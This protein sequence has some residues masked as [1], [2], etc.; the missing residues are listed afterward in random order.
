MPEVVVF[1]I[2]FGFP[3]L[4]RCDGQIAHVLLTRSPLVY[5]RRGLTARLA[6]VKH[7][8]SVR[9]EPGS[10][11]PLKSCG[12][13]PRREP[14]FGVSR[15]ELASH[16]DAGL[17]KGTVDRK[18]DESLASADGA[19]LSFVDFW[20]AVEFSRIKRAPSH[21]LSV[22]F[23]GNLVKLTGLLRLR[24]IGTGA[25]R[26]RTTRLDLGVPDAAGSPRLR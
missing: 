24:Q 26:T 23:G 14:R 13:S 4:S 15:Q 2:S 22:V 11:S 21:N 7:A 8:A 20:H 1:G 3:E 5:P 6:C 16:R 12:C 19:L 9:P 10:N 17:T 25:V 18:R